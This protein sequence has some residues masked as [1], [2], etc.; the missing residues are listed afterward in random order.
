MQFPQF[1]VTPDSVR[2][3]EV[4]DIV[5]VR[6]KG[7]SDS[8]TTHYVL[9]EAKGVVDDTPFVE[10]TDLHV[11]GYSVTLSRRILSVTDGFWAGLSPAE[12]EEAMEAFVAAK[13]AASKR[14]TE[15]LGRYE[16]AHAEHVA[17][18]MLADR[19]WA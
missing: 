6:T 2:V 16:E 14:E 11:G 10:I 4:G 8:F 18:Q 3:L 19:M 7:Y 12:Y 5:K 13:A 15:A 17:Y 1:T 9:I